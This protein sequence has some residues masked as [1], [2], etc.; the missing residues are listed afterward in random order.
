[1]CE[2]EEK[3]RTRAEPIYN[4]IHGLGLGS[5]LENMQNRWAGSIS[6]PT[7]TPKKK[8]KPTRLQP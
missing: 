7:E 1:M 3:I 8:T 4:R 2:T 6:G 5:D